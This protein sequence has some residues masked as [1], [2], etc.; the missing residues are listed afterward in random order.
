[1]LIRITDFHKKM[2][3]FYYDGFVRQVS[4]TDGRSNTTITAYNDLGQVSYTQSSTNKTYYFYNNLGQRTMVSNAL[5]QVSHT[6]YNPQGQTIATW[7]TSYPVAYEFN[8]AGRM[9]AIATT[10]SNEYANVNLNTLLAEGK[11][12]SDCNIPA[13]DITQWF[14]NETTGLLT[15]KIYADGNGPSYTYTSSGKLYTRTWARGKT[16]TYTYGDL[17][18]I[19]KVDYSDSTPNVTYTHDRL[20]RTTSATSLA[21]TSTFHYDGLTLD[22]ET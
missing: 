12:L 11:T 2:K 9:I 7:G 1:M 8:T 4:V 10:R 19:T 15:Q 20:G 6:A 17:G 16:T 18:Q 3:S 22:Y 13:L 14:Y 21:S 5:G